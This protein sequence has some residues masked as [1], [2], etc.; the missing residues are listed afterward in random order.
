MPADSPTIHPAVAAVADAFAAWVDAVHRTRDE[1]RAEITD[2]G[3]DP[4]GPDVDTRLRQVLAAARDELD[5]P[6]RASFDRVITG[7]RDHL[8]ATEARP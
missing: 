4:D 1:I 8:D 6:G 5:E 2:E 3:G 7:M